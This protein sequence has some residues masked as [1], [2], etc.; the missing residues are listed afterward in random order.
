MVSRRVSNKIELIEFILFVMAHAVYAFFIEKTELG[1]SVLMYA[2]ITSI[3]AGI[4]LYGI[5]ELVPSQIGFIICIMMATYLI[6]T[7]L[8]TLAFGVCIYMVAGALISIIGNMRLNL[9]YII[10]V[11]IAIVLG[12]TTQYDVITQ[13]VNMDFYIMLVLFCEGALITECMMGFICQQKVE[14]VER[15]N[16][17]LNVAQKSKDEFLANMSHEI[18]TPMNA[19][20]GMSELIMREPK[21]TDQIREYCY[22]IQTSGENLL[23]II[24][25]ILDFSKIESGKMDIVNESYSIASVIQDV[26]NTAVLR[27]GYKDIDIIIEASPKLPKL[28][29]GDAIRN[30]QILI[31]IVSNAVKFTEKGY[32][33]VEISCFERDG[34]NWLKMMVEDT[35]IGIRK[36]EQSSLFE[37]FSRL[38]TKRNR[39]VE[40]TGLGL[41]ICK[42]L[43]EAMHGRISL[44]SEYGKGTTVTVELPQPVE[45]VSPFLTLKA[46]KDMQVIV[47]GDVENSKRFGDEWYKSINAHFWDAFGVPYR[48]MNDFD[49]L[50]EMIEMKKVTHLFISMQE[51]TNHRMVYDKASLDTKIFVTFDPQYPARFSGHVRGIRAP[52]YSINLVTALNG[53]SLYNQYIDER[54][55]PIEFQAPEARILVVDDNE[56]NLRVAAGVLKLYQ[57]DVVLSAS[58]KEALE[59]LKKQDIDLV[60]MDHMMPEMD[61]IE[62]VRIIRKIGGEY[63]KNLPVIALT[64][65]VVNDAKEMFLDSGFQDFLPKPIG[66][67]LVDAIL[68]K[69]LPK[70]KIVWAASQYMQINEAAALEN[71]GGQKDL[72]K[73]LLEYCLELEDQRWGEIQ[74]SFEKEDFK[75]YEIRVH[76]LKGAMRSLGVDEMA[77]VS[78]R[79][80]HACKEGEIEK[81]K[82]EHAYL[83]EEYKRAHRSIEVFLKDYEI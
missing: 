1:V 22:N 35:G 3:A 4:C 28:F 29:Y 16:D 59:I 12:I 51:Y 60:F 25:D 69:W 24:N 57:A 26:A 52:F 37:S 58:G 9:Y 65:N 43:T 64:A 34:E 21:A 80:E 18:R 63:E 83:Y 44:C 49:E 30:R 68:R 5:K 27:K 41:A 46:D 73:E 45:D 56:I 76:A 20:V 33:Y 54:E 38:D 72:F 74:E 79:Q 6:G 40:G 77:K 48:L 75:E 71:M 23:A 19:I 42:R 81:V 32:V 55:V 10:I 14:E 2:V 62:T 82:A 13:E 39:S 61:G 7:A 67:R 70:E 53:E 31:N 11:N 50:V 78:E 8:G 17:L 15:Q 66:L 47:F 36:E